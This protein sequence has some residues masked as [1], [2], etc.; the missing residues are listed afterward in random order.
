V[1]NWL[2]G[3]VFYNWNEYTASDVGQ[4]NENFKGS[5]YAHGGELIANVFQHRETFVDLTAGLR[6]QWV[7]TTNFAGG[8]TIVGQGNF[9]LPMY[10]ARLER[11]TDT[12]VTN[13]SVNAETNISSFTDEFS[14]IDPATGFPKLQELGRTNA[15]SGWTT[16]SWDLSQSVYLDP[17]IYGDRWREP[18]QSKGGHPT[19]AHELAVAFRGQYAFDARLIPNFEQ[20]AGGMFS[21][22]GYPEAVVAGDNVYVGTIE[23]RLHIPQIL[24][25][26][27][28]PGKLFGK[29]FRYQPQTPYGRADWDL[30]AKAFV[31][32]GRTENNNRQTDERDHTL[33]GTGVGLELSYKRNFSLRVDWGVALEKIDNPGGTGNVSEGSNRF[34]ILAT[35]L[36]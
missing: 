6:E 16:L 28:E 23:Y 30:I 12:A 33:V 21:V 14:H 5:G 17:L 35:I 25:Y 29:S 3:R 2:R 20:I 26:E 8:Q 7:Q 1:G 34:H 24:G 22:R 13:F 31:D 10:G 36:F 9:L 18:D 19:L 15:D 11:T 32:A 4:T 27:S